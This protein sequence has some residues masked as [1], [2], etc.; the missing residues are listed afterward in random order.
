MSD[1]SIRL[2]AAVVRAPTYVHS[3]P[4]EVREVERDVHVYTHGYRSRAAVAGKVEANGFDDLAEEPCK[5][6]ALMIAVDASDSPET[7]P[8]HKTGCVSL[9]LKPKHLSR[10]SI[11][12]ERT[13]CPICISID[14]VG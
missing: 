13:A 6:Q 10:T 3:F 5:L 12:N 4:A 7:V 1:P 9:I 11:R 8:V 14:I 2:L